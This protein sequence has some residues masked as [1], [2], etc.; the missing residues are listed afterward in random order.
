M[1]NALRYELVRLRSL[2]STWVLLGSALVLQF[3]SAMAYAGHTDLTPRERFVYPFTGIT[4]VLVSLL[5][6]AVAVAS[7]GHEYRYRTITTTMLTLPSRGRILAAKVLTVTAVA[8]ATGAGL[9]AVT[10]LA[11]AIHGGIP[12]ELWRVGQV[13][14][15]VVVYLVLSAMVGLGIAAVTRNATL[16][17][18]AV[19]AF[20]TVVEVILLLATE[21]SERLLPFSAAANMVSPQSGNVWTMPLPLLVLAVALVGAG[22]VLLT[23]RDA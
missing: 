10:L 9:V 11:G 15:A 12:S 6:T 17:M 19:L 23:R 5:P 13:L 16:A 22:G 8:A 2:R 3:V 14:A 1:L 20:P 7:F 18:I 4:L 21:I